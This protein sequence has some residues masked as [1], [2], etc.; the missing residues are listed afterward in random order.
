MRSIEAI[1]NRAISDSSDDDPDPP[2]IT[3]DVSDTQSHLAVDP[4]ALARL[5]RE[6]L[7]A[8]AVNA[9]TI[10]LAIVDNA[11]I[12]AINRRHLDHDWPTDVITF[13]LS[14]DEDDALAGELIVSA[15]M[16]AAT[17]SEAGIAAR[18][19]LALYVVHGLLHLCGYDDST[20]AESAAMRRREGE[21]LARLGHSNTFSAVAVSEAGLAEAGHGGGSGEGERA[22]WTV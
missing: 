4:A 12:H 20:P 7:A 16:A 3:V 10:S 19:E 22:Q 13:C 18:D 11:T 21:V 1:M 6:A 8:E 15:E 9:A 14:D 5:V 2:G 17:A